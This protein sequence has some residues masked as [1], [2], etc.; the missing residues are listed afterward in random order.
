MLFE[1]DPVCKMQ[2][3]PDTA[4]AKYDYN[5]RTYYFCATRCMERF[6]AN[7]QQFLKAPPP[8]SAIH[9]PPSAIPYTCPMH[10]EVRQLGPGACPKCGMALEPEVASLEEEENPELRDM[11]R[12]FWIAAVLTV[13]VVVAGMMEIA[14]LAQL[15]LATPVVVVA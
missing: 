1:T 5:G 15:L 2:V 14:P 8:T 3:L 11:T 6:R 9:H 10:P 12:R 4:A 7:P 13:P